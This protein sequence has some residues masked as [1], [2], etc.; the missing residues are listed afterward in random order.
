MEKNRKPF[1][2]PNKYYVEILKNLFSGN[3]SS[4]T[5]LLQFLYFANNLVGQEDIYKQYKEIVF[6][7]IKCNEI[8][9]Q[10]IISLGESPIYQNS[11]KVWLSASFLE[12]PKSIKQML[13]CSIE[14]KEKYIIN[15]KFAIS[16]ITEKH[17]VNDLKQLLIINQKHKEILSILLQKNT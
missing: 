2:S 3:V 6:E 5:N 11:Q 13:D 16:K 9:A 8:L 15:L 17:L 4:A 14:I 1:L 10:N 7:E 12:Y